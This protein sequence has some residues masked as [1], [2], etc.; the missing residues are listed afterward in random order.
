MWM[1]LNTKAHDLKSEGSAT[2][3]RSG[4]S[5]G[6][7]TTANLSQNGPLRFHDG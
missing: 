3:W 5:G 6:A 7:T 2:D 1:W 4:G